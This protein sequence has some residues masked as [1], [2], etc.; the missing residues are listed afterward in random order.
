[1]A[2]PDDDDPP[3]EPGERKSRLYRLGKK[4]L[5][6]GDDVRD[7]ASAVIDGS[8]RAKT[9]MVRMI[10]REVRN[11]LDE[12]KLKED[13]MELVRGHSLELKMSV[14]LKPLVPEAEEPASEPAPPAPPPD[15]VDG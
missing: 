14:H 15:E 8:D 10:A 6:R 1:M 7:I 9:E 2:D 11:Y 13:V 4:I 12:L 3:I 5:D